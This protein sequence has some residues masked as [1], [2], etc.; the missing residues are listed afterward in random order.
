MFDKVWYIKGKEM[1]KKTEEQ[2]YCLVKHGVLMQ[3]DRIKLQ[4]QLTE[5]LRVM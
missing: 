5:K 2:N 1:K 4:R 3:R